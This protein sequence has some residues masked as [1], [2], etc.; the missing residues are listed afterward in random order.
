MR[1]QE[2]IVAEVKRLEVESHPLDFTRGVLM[3]FLTVDN[4]QQ[5]L[6]VPATLE[7]W[8]DAGTEETVE[9]CPL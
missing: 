3:E 4:V 5:F 2:E 1:T 8:G 6:A 9:H 7:G